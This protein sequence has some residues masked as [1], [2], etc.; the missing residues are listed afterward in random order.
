MSLLGNLKDQDTGNVENETDSVGGGNG[1]L[2]SGL[3]PGTVK[4]AYLG[5]SPGGALSLTL[6]LATEA[7]REM[8]ETF[9]VTSGDAKGNKKYYETKDGDRKFLPGYNMANSLCLLTVAKPID[10][11][12][13]EKKIVGIYNFQE[14]KDINTEVEVLT[15]LIGQE[16]IAGVQL[17]HENKQVKNDNGMYVDSPDG[18]IRE[19]NEIDKFFR[20]KDKLT[21]AEIRAQQDEPAFYNAWGAKWTDQVRDKVTKT[22]GG[23]ATPAFGGAAAPA[24]GAGAKP[25]KSLFAA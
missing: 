22:A 24:G 13:T 2:A 3:Y 15:D 14:R 7:G 8:R 1:P 5:K 9:W 17:V 4:M 12:D 10:D 11:M 21:T 20:A 16:I 23:A 19:K 25:Q 18:A 6:W